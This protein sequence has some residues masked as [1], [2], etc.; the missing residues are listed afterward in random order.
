MKHAEC[1]LLM[2]EKRFCDAFL[3]GSV[4]PNLFLFFLPH[5]NID[6][7]LFTILLLLIVSFLDS[8]FRSKMFIPGPTGTAKNSNNQTKAH[9]RGKWRQAVPHCHTRARIVHSNTA[10]HFRLTNQ[11]M[12]HNDHKLLYYRIKGEYFIHEQ[13][14]FFRPFLEPTYF[15]IYLFFSPI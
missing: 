6:Q 7:S 2:S 12:R 11:T 4:F 14:L 1:R 10:R 5:F 9:R 3:I 13:G 15:S 8:T